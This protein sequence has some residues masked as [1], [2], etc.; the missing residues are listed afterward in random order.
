MILKVPWFV[1]EICAH[2]VIA[3]LVLRR[4]HVKPSNSAT[5]DEQQKK[6]MGAASIDCLKIFA[7]NKLNI[8][9]RLK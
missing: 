3:A 6:R 9:I 5:Q 7:R 2:A 8:L 1:A 4:R